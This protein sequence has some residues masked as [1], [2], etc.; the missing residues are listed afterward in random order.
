MPTRKKKSKSGRSQA[1]KT[2]VDSRAASLATK[3]IRYP[4]YSPEIAK[5]CQNKHRKNV[6][7]VFSFVSEKFYLYTGDFR[8]E[9]EM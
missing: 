6:L 7:Y 4:K 8:I 1:K 2:V 3:C 5:I 9:L